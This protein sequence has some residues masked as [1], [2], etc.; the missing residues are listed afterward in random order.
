MGGSPFQQDIL[1][2]IEGALAS[3]LPAVERDSAPGLARLFEAMRYSSLNGG[4]RMRP[5]LTV[6]C[7]DLFGVDRKHSLR[8]GA[9]VEMVHCYSLVHDDLP[10]MD[11]S[12]LRRGRPTSHMEY[13]DA[14]AILVGDA[15]LTEA[16]S[17]LGDEQT[18]PEAVTRVR[19][20]QELAQAA[21]A[22]GMVGGQMMDVLSET[23]EHVERDITLLQSL[24]TGALI[25]CACRLGGLLGNASDEQM[26]LIDSYAEN[27]G[28]AFQITDDLLDLDG[29]MEMTGKPVGQDKALEKITFVELLGQDGA[30]AK[31]KE[32]VDEAITAIQT[33]SANTSALEEVARF[34]L[35]RQ[36]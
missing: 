34:I 30:T 36:K 3:L 10:A 27:I 18:H 17:V 16:F 22:R 24:K 2:A 29:D 14:T 33:L 4:K 12:D 7:A 23:G 1:E 15:L 5:Y 32:L 26:R 9:A 8:A 11:D 35:A 21:G 20:V 28:L 13:D 6:I 31:A 19:L 25:R